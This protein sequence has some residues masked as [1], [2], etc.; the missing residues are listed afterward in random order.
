MKHKQAIGALIIHARDLFH[1]Q[2]TA[3]GKQAV[4]AWHLANQAL[5]ALNEGQDGVDRRLSECLA[6]A[7][8]L[9]LKG[10]EQIEAAVKLCGDN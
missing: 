10:V 7:Q 2:F 5:L 9:K 4:E 1:D 6:Q 3:R 8:G